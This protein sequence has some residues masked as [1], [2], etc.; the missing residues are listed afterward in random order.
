MGTEN[1]TSG[2]GGSYLT[3][4]I[5]TFGIGRGN[6][7]LNDVAATQGMKIFVFSPYD[8]IVAV[9]RNLTDRLQWLDGR[10]SYEQAWEL[11]DHHPEAVAPASELAEAFSPA[12]PSKA[13]SATKSSSVTGPPSEGHQQATL[14][15]FFAESSSI[16]SA[17]QT[18]DKNPSAETEKRRIGE[19]WLQQLV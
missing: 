17:S 5:P 15:D 7:E 1:V 3:S 19:L 18:R 4:W 6:E 13:S 14:A 12:T 2:K 16:T 8:C 9:K 11:L 10:G